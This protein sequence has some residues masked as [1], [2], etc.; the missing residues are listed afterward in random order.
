[1]LGHELLSSGKL[2]LQCRLVTDDSLGSHEPLRVAAST[3]LAIWST[4]ESSCENVCRLRAP[5]KT[6]ATMVCAFEILAKVLCNVPD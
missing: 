5:D 1:M 6:L 4:R 2:K 3:L